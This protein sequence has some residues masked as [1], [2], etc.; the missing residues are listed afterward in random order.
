[1]WWSAQIFLPGLR[2]NRD[3]GRPSWIP[4]AAPQSDILSGP[5]RAGAIGS[6]LRYPTPMRAPGGTYSLRTPS[7]LSAPFRRGQKGLPHRAAC[8]GRKGITL[9]AVC[10]GR[11]GLPLRPGRRLQR[12]LDSLRKSK[13][14]L[15][16]SYLLK[17]ALKGISRALHL[18]CLFICLLSAYYLLI[19]CLLSVYLKIVSCEDRLQL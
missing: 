18:I 11:M 8:P 4:E 3:R 15:E 9:L 16:R 10:Q 14:R 13:F 19:I 5:Y 7:L 1:M 6:S 12:A 17:A 2:P